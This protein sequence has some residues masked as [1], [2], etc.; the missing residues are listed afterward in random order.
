MNFTSLTPTES[1][2]LEQK[3]LADAQRILEMQN[4]L[5]QLQE[6][7]DQMMENAQKQE[8]P[9]GHKIEFQ[10]ILPLRQLSDAIYPKE[11]ALRKAVTKLYHDVC[12][13][14]IFID[15][16]FFDTWFSVKPHW[17]LR[18]TDGIERIEMRKVEELKEKA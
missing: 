15:Q 17:V 1:Q 8:F 3:F 16:N 13:G 9:Y 12:T 11:K 2:L 14:N 5:N 6:Q 18:F 10:N 4:E 7:L